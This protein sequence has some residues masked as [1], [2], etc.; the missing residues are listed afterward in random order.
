MYGA[1]AYKVTIVYDDINFFVLFVTTRSCTILLLLHVYTRWGATRSAA[2]GDY[3][4]AV[5]AQLLA[6]I[7]NEEVV[8]VLAQVLQDLVRGM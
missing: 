8:R 6:Q 4:I 5:G 2:G 7:R 1:F 3:I